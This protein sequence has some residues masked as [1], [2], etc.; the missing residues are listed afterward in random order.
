MSFHFGVKEAGAEDAAETMVEAEVRAD[1]HFVPTQPDGA[2]GLPAGEYVLTA[3][4]EQ[5]EQDRFGGKYSDP[6][7]PF[8]TIRVTEGINLLRP[9]KLP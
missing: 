8:A 1:G 4:W 9:F 7:K 3:R 2:I 6:E 5:A